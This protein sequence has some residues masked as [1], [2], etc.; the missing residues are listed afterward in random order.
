MDKNIHMETPYHFH[1]A[2]S[3]YHLA[4]LSNKLNMMSQTELQLFSC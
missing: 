1:S 4:S 3:T 2:T